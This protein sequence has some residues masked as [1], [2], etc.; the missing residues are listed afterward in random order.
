MQDNSMNQLHSQITSM[1]KLV[2]QIK[3]ENLFLRNRLATMVQERAELVERKN[4]ALFALKRIVKQL[5]HFKE[6]HD[7]ESA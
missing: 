3:S 1:V 5:K 6:Y 2:D 7:V 4:K